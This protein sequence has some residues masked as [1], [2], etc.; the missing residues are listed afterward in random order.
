MESLAEALKKNY[1]LNNFV[2]EKS[3]NEAKEDASFTKFIEK[4]KIPEKILMKHTSLL[5]KSN[6]ELKNCKNCKN[7]ANC[8]NEVKG[9][10]YYPNYE[11]N[12][13]AFYYVPCKY[14]K[15][16]EEKTKYQ[17]NIYTF[18]IPKEIKNAKMKDIYTDDPNRFETIKWLKNFL[19]NYQKDKFIKGLYLTGNFGT[20]KT[21]LISAMLN[22]LAKKGSKIAI[23]YFPEFLRSLKA[24]FNDDESYNNTFNYIK[25]IELLLI[26]DI[27][28]ETTTPW[29]RDEIL[30]TILQYRMQQQ[31]PTFFTSNLNIKELEEHLSTTSKNIDLVKSRRIIE[32]IKYLTDQIIMISENKR[33]WGK[34]MYEEQ[35]EE[36]EKENTTVETTIDDTT[37]QIEQEEKGYIPSSIN[38]GKITFANKPK[39]LVRRPSI[40]GANIGPS[41]KGFAKMAGLGIILAVLAVIMLVIFNRM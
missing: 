22:E 32:R 37:Y 25:K 36:L 18:D 3:F 27:G 1:H 40:F 19:D 7:L 33:K 30:G 11:E 31:L 21:Y 16:F 26:D 9:H 14:Q 8:Q 4:L 39:T 2:L 24:S 13:L 5:Q 38:N 6:S 41:N 28:A 12:N 10:I 20:G 29:G 23:I 15:E 17:E 35:K 34:I